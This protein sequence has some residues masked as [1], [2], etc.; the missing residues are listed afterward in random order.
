M[1]SAMHM[2]ALIMVVGKYN[3]LCMQMA[4]YRRNT[5]VP[6]GLYMGFIA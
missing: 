2:C 4:Q 1:I 6:R 3:F 5:I